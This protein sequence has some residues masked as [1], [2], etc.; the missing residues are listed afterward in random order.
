MICDIDDG[1]NNFDVERIR[2]SDLII[3][4]Y[5]LEKEAPNKTLSILSELKNSEH[6]NMV[7]VYTREQLE[8]VWM[9]IA[10][11]L[12]GSSDYESGLINY[13]VTYFWEEDVLPD[14]KSNGGL[15]S[16]SRNEIV[17]YIKIGKIP[18]RLIGALHQDSSISEHKEFIAKLICEYHVRYYKIIPEEHQA[19]IIFGDESGVQWIQAGNIFISLY[20]KS[21]GSYES[22]AENIWNKLNQS[23]YEWQRSYYKLLKSEIKN[24]IESEALSFDVHLSNDICGQAAWLNEIIKT[25]DKD[26]RD[27]KIDVIFSNLSEDLYLKIKSNIKLRGFINSVFEAYKQ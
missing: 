8:V 10:C 5:H 22:D 26:A 27:E 14:L 4:D 6:L 24:R 25:E 7:V 3:I 21:Q 11:M 17:T 12:K 19:E 9:Q 16:L 18:G 13:D 23:L 1:I 15:Y 2:K 20:H